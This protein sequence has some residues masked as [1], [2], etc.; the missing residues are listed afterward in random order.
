L[1]LIIKKPRLLKPRF[2]DLINFLL[3]FNYSYCDHVFAA[4]GGGVG[5]GVGGVPTCGSSAPGV[6]PVAGLVSPSISVN[7]DELATPIIG[8]GIV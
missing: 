5:V 3:R 6:A 8:A 2:L 1:I 7:I 4:L